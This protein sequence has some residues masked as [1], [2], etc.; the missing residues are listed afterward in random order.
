MKNVLLTL[1]AVFVFCMLPGVAHAGADNSNWAYCT[2][3]AD[4][5]GYCSG[6]PAGFKK[7]PG[8]G[9]Q[10]KFISTTYGYVWFNAY[11]ANVNYTCTFPFNSA[12]T[13]NL[14]NLLMLNRGEFNISWDK[15][16]TCTYVEIYN[17]SM[18]P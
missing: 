10:S 16:G 2:K 3:A 12:N 6:S 11:L 18:V 7:S 13:N 17:S 4:G 15:T 8:A 1:G 14:Y 5:S 9:D